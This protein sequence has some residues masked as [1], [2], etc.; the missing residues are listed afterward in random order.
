VLFTLLLLLIAIRSE[1]E[2]HSP[3]CPFVKGEFT[4]NVPLSG[5][6]Q[7][8]KI[9]I[10]LSLPEHWFD[11]IAL[12]IVISQVCQQ[13]RIHWFRHGLNIAVI[14]YET[15]SLHRIDQNDSRKL[16]LVTKPYHW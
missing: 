14:V 5:R 9:C 10:Y 1:H 13:G 4:Q 3:Q 11:H 16:D 15:G 7:L 6:S 12:G 8:R 2:R